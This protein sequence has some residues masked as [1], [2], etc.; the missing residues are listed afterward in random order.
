MSSLTD[1]F[2]GGGGVIVAAGAVLV[3]VGLSETA[4]SHRS[5]WSNPWF[6]IGCALVALGLT[7]AIGSISTSWLRSRRRDPS[8]PQQVQPL[9]VGL[10]DLVPESR[11][12]PLASPLHLR[13]V[14]ESWRLIYSAVWAFGIAV[15]ITNLTEKPI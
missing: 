13:C 15:Q 5:T 12:E 9:G 8:L 3:G 4:G 6:A 7:F 1:P 14:D 2:V 11:L 10:A